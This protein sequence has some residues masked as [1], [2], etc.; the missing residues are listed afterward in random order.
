MPATTGDALVSAAFQNLNVF[1][2]GEALPGPDGDFALG[3]LNRMI[4][5]WRQRR[6]FVPIIARERFD[7]TADKGGPTNPYTIGD[8]GDFDTERPANQ[9]AIKAANLILTSTSPEVRVPLGI[10]TT[11][12][13]DAN[14]LPGMTSE[15]P[16]ALFYNPTYASDLG[17]I[18]LWPVP[19]TAEN[20]LELFLQKPIAKFADLSTEYYLPDGADDAITYQLELRLAGP[21]GRA[22]PDEDRRLAVESLGAFKR[23]NLQLS[24]LANDASWAQS[25]RTL[26][27]IDTGS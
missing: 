24:D 3:V 2:P 1:L 6:L 5:Q 19:D 13:Y 8:G 4:S 9:N 26:F 25:R 12:A 11:D 15:Q 10:Y 21:Y 27:N 18:Y 16:T 7:M 20:D 14:Q 22:V 23:S 17:S